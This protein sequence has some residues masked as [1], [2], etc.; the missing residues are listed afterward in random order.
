MKSRALIIRGH[1]GVGKTTLSQYIAEDHAFCRIS[2][3]DIYV[4]VIE[5]YGDHKAAS[6]IAYIAMR[7][8]LA[9][10]PNSGTNFVLDAP[11]NGTLGAEELMSDLTELGFAAKSVLVLC[12]DRDS[13]NKRLQARIGQTSPN[14]LLT[15]LDDIISYRGSLEVEPFAGELVVDTAPG[16]APSKVLAQQCVNY[17][18]GSES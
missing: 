9:A 15:S 12:S 17:L 4:P 13:W 10:N 18:A 1:Q 2:K 6:N 11:F 3:D 14:H 8:I 5:A 7:S 16:S